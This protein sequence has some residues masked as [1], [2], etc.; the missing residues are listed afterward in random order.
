MTLTYGLF[1]QAFQEELSNHS[2]VNMI[3]EMDLED[4]AIDETIRDWVKVR[5]PLSYGCTEIV[6]QTNTFMFLFFSLNCLPITK[7]SVF[8][9]LRH[10]FFVT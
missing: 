7:C 8:V 10:D 4:P 2:M 5:K 9:K 3:L 1:I 6:E